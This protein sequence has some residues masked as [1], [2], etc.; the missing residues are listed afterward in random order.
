[1]KTLT[2]KEQY[3]SDIENLDR[4]SNGTLK[5]L[6]DEN[7]DWFHTPIPIKLLSN[8]KHIIDGGLYKNFRTSL[9]ILCNEDFA[10]LH[11]FKISEHSDN[12]IHRYTVHVDISPVE[13][14]E[15]CQKKCDELNQ[16]QCTEDAVASVVEIVQD[17]PMFLREIITRLSDAA[18]YDIRD[19]LL[20]DGT[21]CEFHVQVASNYSYK[22]VI[23]Q[24]GKFN[25]STA[26]VVER[27]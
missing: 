19:I 2:K 10:N 5:K 15:K 4:N 21:S 11:V 26:K 7:I 18:H 12:L 25:P 20:I 23:E 13:H 16:H 27:D 9:N 24:I 6:N 3:D 8:I 14:V 22:F 17:F 1:M